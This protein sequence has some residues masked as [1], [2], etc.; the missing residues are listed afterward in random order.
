MSGAALEQR[1]TLSKQPL[2]EKSGAKTFFYTGAGRFERLLV[3][4]QGSLFPH[5]RP[6]Q[7]S[8]DS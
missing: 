4:V 3:R 2:F 5:R 8:A 6:A 1:M 7:R